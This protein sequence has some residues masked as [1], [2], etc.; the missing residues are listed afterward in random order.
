[1]DLVGPGSNAVTECERVL[2]TLPAWFGIESSL[3]EYA[4]ATKSLPTFAV[5][6]G[7]DVVGFITLHRHRLRLFATSS[8]DSVFDVV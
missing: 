3:M 1:M 4:P 5:L 7:G 2:R 8:S 6:E